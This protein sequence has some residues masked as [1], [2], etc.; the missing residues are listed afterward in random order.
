MIPESR[1]L[2]PSR[3]RAALAYAG[4]WVLVAGVYA[5]LF[6]TMSAHAVGGGAQRGRDDASERAA[7]A[8]LAAPGAPL[9]LAGRREERGRL[10]RA[11]SPRSSGSRSPRR[12]DG[13]LLIRLDRRL[14]PPATP[15]WPAA[16][17]RRSGSSSSTTS[18][19]ARSSRSATRRTRRAP[20]AEERGRTARADV[21]RARAEL[22]APALAAPSALRAERAARDARSRPPR[23]G[24]RRGGARAAGR[25]AAVRPVG[26]T[27][28]AATGCRSRGSGTS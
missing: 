4:A 26:R 17:G 15:R 23:P 13:S 10:A 24:A 22:A 21:L 8:G 11:S 6:A 18:S 2:E 9:A 20:C 7:R 27:R 25:A 1:P 3:R 16:R 12:R 19:T 14:F 28:R 5:G